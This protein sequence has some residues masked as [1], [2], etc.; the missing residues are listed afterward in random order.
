RLRESESARD[1]L[2]KQFA[3]NQILGKSKAV[4]ELRE[5]IK[6]I[7]SC[8]VTVLITGESGTGKELVA[9]AVHYLSQRAG[10]AFIPVHCGALPENLFENELFGHVGGAFTGA[11]VMQS[12]LVK[13]AEGGTLFLD[14]IGTISP[15][16]QIK[17]LR[18]L[19]E[20]EYKPL[21]SSKLHKADTRIIAVAN[22][23]LLSLVKEGRFREDLFYRLNIAS[24]QIPPL[25][26]RVEDIPILIEHF[27]NKY[28][29]KYH[30]PGINISEDGMAEFISYQWPGNVRELENTI[31]KLIVM[32][33]DSVIDIKNPN[34]PF[35]FNGESMNAIS[36]ESF[37]FAKK[38]VVDSFERNYLF[39]LLKDYQ[40]DVNSA[41]KH[42][43][44]S[45]TALWNL[46]KRH[47]LS[48]RDFLQMR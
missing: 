2:R 48:P 30:K 24:V 33:T 27:V 10:K 16:I 9:R 21:G 42:A 5:Q 14:E 23:D 37:N 1:A 3:L 12:G 34:L 28:S 40:G 13:E 46:L 8:D 4:H 29:G 35:Q 19:Q 20:G 45:R 31:Q 6:L 18:L 7:S 32:S 41:A 17:L 15:F 39:K 43:G 38:R 47:N 22:I 11:S 26:E 25:K 36:A 44:K